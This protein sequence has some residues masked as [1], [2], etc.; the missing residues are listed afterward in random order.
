[1]GPISRYATEFF[2]TIQGK[3]KTDWI[4]RFLLAWVYLFFLKLKNH[5]GIYSKNG[6]E[7]KGIKNIFVSMLNG[8]IFSVCL[9]CSVW[10]N[11]SSV[12]YV[13]DTIMDLKN[14]EIIVD[15]DVNANSPNSV[16]YL[17]EKIDD[18]NEILNGVRI[19]DYANSSISKPNLVD[20]TVAYNNIRD[21]IKIPADFIIELAAITSFSFQISASGEYVI[22][23]GDG[24]IENITKT[25]TVLTTYSHT[26]SVSQKYTVLLNGMATGYDAS[27]SVPAITF[28]NSTNKEK[29]TAVYGSLGKIF[30]TVNGVNPSFYQAFLGLKIKTVPATLFSGIN[31]STMRPYMFYQLFY[32]TTLQTLPSGLF[33]DLSGEPSNYMF[34]QL[35]AYNGSLNSIPA[36]LFSGLYGQPGDYAFARMFVSTNI[37]EIPQG[38]FSGINGVPKNNL[39]Y[40]TFAS[41]KNVKSIPADLFS[42]IRGTPMHSTF[43]STFSNS[44]IETVPAG[45]FSGIVGV[46]STNT[47]SN[48]FYNCTSLKTIPSGLFS[49]ITRA[50]YG[51]FSS[52][53][54]GCTSLEKIP[55]GLFGT[56]TGALNTNAFN[57]TFMGCT[58]LTEIEDG[59]WDI[60]GVTNASYNNMFNSTFAGCTALT[61]AS[62]TVAAGNPTK[63]WE[64]F[65]VYTGQ[66]AFNGNEFMADYDDIPDAWK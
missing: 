24:T 63:L 65:T 29:I 56:I 32:T 15:E 11:L 31:G 60:S 4:S 44:G 62:P 66:G 23:W 20:S 58:S 27:D 19:T 1:M 21:M 10:A 39:F 9:S 52:T 35:N 61:S 45:L 6:K 3:A 26:Y 48:T 8:L 33:A 42:G 49:G 47:F 14:I 25:D 41:C 54:K 55:T 18:A 50:G 51:T 59:I 16:R 5:G 17:L 12:K 13:H 37:K 22:D 64:K 38:L 46:G 40:E 34:Y 36:D 2:V 57:Q 7:I 43:S 30:G 53:F 28:N